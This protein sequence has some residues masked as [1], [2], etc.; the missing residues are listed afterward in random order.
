MNPEEMIKSGLD[1]EGRYFALNVLATAYYQILREYGGDQVEADQRFAQL[2]GYNP[3]ALLISKS[4]E[5]RRTPY[6]E[7]GLAQANEELFQDLPDA[8]YYFHPDSPLDE[9]SYVAIQS[10]DADAIGGIARYDL[11][12]NEWAAFTIWL[13]VD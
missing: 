11:Q 2:F 12:L 8:A 3:T 9:F 6:T 13:Q 4:K 7:P 10:F 5:V 1:P